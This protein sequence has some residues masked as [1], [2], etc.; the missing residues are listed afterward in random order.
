MVGFAAKFVRIMRSSI[1]KLKNL[2]LWST[3]CDAELEHA[4]FCV[5]SSLKE[6]IL[7][8]DNGSVKLH[9]LSE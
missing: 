5:I 6:D 4:T 7:S 1:V 2:N 9:Q 8:A 3:C